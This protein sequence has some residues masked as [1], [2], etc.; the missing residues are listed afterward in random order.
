MKIDMKTQRDLK[1]GIS[2]SLTG[3][4]LFSRFA[5]ARRAADI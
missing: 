4:P 5:S 2:V 3:V 1:Q